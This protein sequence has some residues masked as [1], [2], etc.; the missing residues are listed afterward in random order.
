MCDMD[1]VIKNTESILGFKYY[2]QKTRGQF[3]HIYV[4]VQAGTI[5]GL[6]K[7]NVIAK[8]TLGHLPEAAW[9]QSIYAVYFVTE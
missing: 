9:S 4:H 8:V 7:E 5:I 3:A 2:F 1:D 6:E